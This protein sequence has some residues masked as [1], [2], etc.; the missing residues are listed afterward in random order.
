VAL[1]RL[2]PGAGVPIAAV[3]RPGRIAPPPGNLAHR[4]GSHKA[5]ARSVGVTHVQVRFFNLS[6][7]ITAI[8]GAAVL[9]LAF[10]LITSRSG[11][12]NGGSYSPSLIPRACPALEAVRPA[13][14]PAGSTDCSMLPPGKEF[15]CWLPGVPRRPI[16]P[17]DK[18]CS[19][20]PFPPGD[21][22]S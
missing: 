3:S 14:A 5:H 15:A 9:L 10:H 8:I 22:G 17:A 18:P 2:L 1:A 11:R 12:S 21:E 13:E 16:R 7:W 19:G 20:C 6:T 4:D